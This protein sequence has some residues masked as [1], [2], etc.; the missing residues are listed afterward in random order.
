MMKTRKFILDIDSISSGMTDQITEKRGWFDWIDFEIVRLGTDIELPYPPALM[1]S[2][3]GNLIA[4]LR[5]AAGLSCALP[6]AVALVVGESS[7]IR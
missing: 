6:G 7:D 4:Q 2:G 3:Y 1:R 5:L